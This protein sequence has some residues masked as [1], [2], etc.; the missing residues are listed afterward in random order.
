MR[1]R[2]NREEGCS[3]RDAQSAN[4]P[5]TEAAAPDEDV[6]RADGFFRSLE[7]ALE[8]LA[9][10]LRGDEDDTKLQNLKEVTHRLLHVSA[11]DDAENQAGHSRHLDDFSLR[12]H[13]HLRQDF[14]TKLWDST[15]V[16][17]RIFKSHTCCFGLCF[18]TL[19][20][21]RL[22]LDGHARLHKNIVYLGYVLVVVVTIYRAFL[23][24]FQPAVKRSVCSDEIP[25]CDYESISSPAD[26]WQEVLAKFGKYYFSFILPLLLIGSG[27]HWYIHKS[28][29]V[30]EK[31]WAFLVV[32][33]VYSLI[34]NGITL[35]SIHLQGYKWA[36]NMLAITIIWVCASALK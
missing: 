23:Q 2:D 28:N 11:E 30:K 21:E 14:T 24:I 29:R 10:D 32:F 1:A 25:F 34:L 18:T 13:I 27:L 20:M 5:L 31:W 19:R 6:D 16:E 4:R 33:I 36:N 3:R 35:Q 7:S 22:F 8:G 15:P 26:V 12:R 17:K 9:R